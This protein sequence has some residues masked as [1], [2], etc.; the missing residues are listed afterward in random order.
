MDRY[1]VRLIAVVVSV[2]IVAELL[3]RTVSVVLFDHLRGHPP[4][5]NIH[6]SLVLGLI[7]LA[8]ATV[9]FAVLYA[10]WVPHRITEPDVAKTALARVPDA[11]WTS[12]KTVALME[13]PDGMTGFEWLIPA[14][15]ILLVMWLL[16]VL[17]AW[18]IGSLPRR[19]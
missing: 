11:T 19:S 6:R 14:A 7:N 4:V 15:E 17:V 5:A 3:Q 1:W 12:L 9:G 18:A 8:Q 2:Y 16:L 13:T 10:V